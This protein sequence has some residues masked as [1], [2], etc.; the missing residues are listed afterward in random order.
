MTNTPRWLY[1]FPGLKGKDPTETD[2][3]G[4]GT[5]VLSKAAGATYGVAKS[6]S[7]VIVK[8]PGDSVVACGE[9]LANV[10]IFEGFN[11]IADDIAARNS[12]RAILNLSFVFMGKYIST[13]NSPLTIDV[14]SRYIRRRIHR[15][16]RN[17]KNTSRKND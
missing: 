2:P 12:G 9:K 7:V 1:I 8:C 11:I 14:D 4:H 15:I 10:A 3:S 6:A 5:C 16:H 13:S 17:I